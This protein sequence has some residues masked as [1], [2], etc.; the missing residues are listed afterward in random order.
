MPA[1]E[2]FIGKG[3]VGK[4]TLAAAYAVR[5]AARH[6]RRRLLLI[7]TDPAH[8]LCDVFGIRLGG[9]PT[10]IRTRG[11]LLAWQVNAYSEFRRF[12]DHYRESIIRLVESGTVFTRK[13]I[14]PL[15]DTTLPG[16]AEIA[17]LLSIHDALT[18]G[19]YE[20]IIVDTAPAGHTLRLF[21][22]P[23]HFV[24][25][26]DFLDVAASRDQVLADTFGGERRISH[27][28]LAQWRRMVEDVRQALRGP[29]ARLV[30][31]TTPEEFALNESI[32]MRDA[33]AISDVPLVVHTVVVN[34]AVR[35]ATRCTLCLRRAKATAAAIRCV[36][37]EFGHAKMLLAEDQGQPVLGP[38]ALL[39]FSQRVFDGKKVRMPEL[40]PRSGHRVV[41]LVAT[42]WPRLETALTL[43]CG[44]GGVGKTTISAALAFHEREASRARIT[45]CSTDPAPSLDD[46]FDQDVGDHAVAVLGDPALQAI[47]I[48]SVAHFRTWAREMRD[49]LE[50]ALATDQNGVHIDLSFERRVFSALLD[51]VP[52]GVDEVFAILRILDLIAAR[53]GKVM[54]D[55]APTGHALEL[56][57][58]PERLLLWTR[59]L[60]KTLAAHRTLPLAQ[61]LAVE[62][63]TVGQR[64]RDLLT[65]LRD[66]RQAL[67]VPVMLA[68]PMPDRETERLL[69][70]A[71]E[72]GAHAAPLF[73]NRV[74]FPE[75]VQNCRRCAQAR[76]WQQ[77][78]LASVARRH[79]GR[80]VYIV[81]E[82]GEEIAG[83]RNL[84]QFTRHLW[85]IE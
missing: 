46:V 78:T 74:L 31:V 10:P 51:V 5:A 1:L 9:H 62:I 23:E 14:E 24:R 7:S 48:D 34:R 11:S 65:R 80:P 56:L 70:A 47:E 22:M 37:R 43:T 49:R 52:P 6:P 8:S 21:E 82:F 64:V 53:R 75:Q 35:G 2:F 26:L 63:A 60:L 38:A 30:L 29:D 45:I 39:A 73:V 12:L 84:R 55:M 79:R 50:T 42:K 17:A 13:E 61:D 85:Q 57:R 15:L 59:L 3:G 83:K 68:E 33:L 19:K 66:K 20:G 58:M 40:T 27:P 69:T 32:R 28:F 4:T 76:R 67:L 16:M 18:S 81:T 25:F 44:K 36:R 54:I 77:A 72:I 71:D 41:Q